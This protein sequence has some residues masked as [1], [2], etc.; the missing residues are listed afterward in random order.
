MYTSLFYITTYDLLHYTIGCNPYDQQSTMHG[1]SNCVIQT[2]MDGL[3]FSSVCN[4]S[5][6]VLLTMS[7]LFR[8][9]DQK[10]VSK[11]HQ[12]TQEST[13][14]NK[15]Q[16]NHKQSHCGGGILQFFQWTVVFLRMP[17]DL[18]VGTNLFVIQGISVFPFPFRLKILVSGFASF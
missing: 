12:A 5:Q 16:H 11:N 17:W 2:E 6:A 14:K 1:Q 7:Y 8:C 3:T 10:G 4:A 18:P 13:V 15:Y 9:N